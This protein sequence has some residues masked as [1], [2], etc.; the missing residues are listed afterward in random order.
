MHKLT[1][2]TM[3][4]RVGYNNLTF[5]DKI[6]YRDQEMDTKWNILA[7]LQNVAMKQNAKFYC[8]LKS[9]EKFKKKFLLKC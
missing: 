6:K 2:L 8:I 7:H 1:S 5:L 3:V 4:W 9:V